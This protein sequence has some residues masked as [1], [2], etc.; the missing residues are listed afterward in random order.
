MEFKNLIK[1][2][3]IIAE[4]Q[5]D[6]APVKLSIGYSDEANHVNASELVIIDCPPSTIEA[7]ERAGFKISASEMA[8]GLLVEDFMMR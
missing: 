8:G 5:K 7:L 4:S 3:N 2:L 1:A 6:S